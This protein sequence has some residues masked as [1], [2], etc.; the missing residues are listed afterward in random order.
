MMKPIKIFIDLSHIGN[1]NGIGLDSKNILDA[2]SKKVGIY[3][4]VFSPR[5]EKRIKSL[6]YKV[7]LAFGGRPALVDVKDIDIFFQSQPGYLQ[8]SSPNIKWV[9]RL[10]DIFPVTDRQWFRR[11]SAVYFSKA[12]ENAIR[13]QAFF[14]CNSVTTEKI[15]LEYDPSLVGR[16]E[17]FYCQPQAQQSVLCGSCGGCKYLSSKNRSNH[18]IAIGT[19]EP[20]KN[21]QQLIRVW[22]SMS[23]SFIV[24][25]RLVIVGKYG[26]KSKK[27]RIILS[28]SSQSNIF[29]LRECCSSSLELLMKGAKAF[30]STSHNEGFNMPA[31]EARS[32][33]EIRIIL[34][35]VPIHR[36]IHGDA[37]EYFRSDEELINLL[38]KNTLH[39]SRS[40]YLS[41]QDF[42]K[43]FEVFAI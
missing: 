29:W 17:V 7:R 16:T 32:W 18:H 34:S 23:S 15:L 43:L 4:F 13:N 36:E 39:S 6:Y 19:L 30:I 20:R 40:Q 27:M 33:A 24:Q 8:P 1:L 42:K 31:L 21:Y 9:V 12:L 41:N 22:K 35:D 2:I 10:H 37:V 28:R 14:L 11:I 26:W 38:G 25:N 3:Q 5:R